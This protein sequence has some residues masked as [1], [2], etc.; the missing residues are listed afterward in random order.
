MLGLLDGKEV[1]IS[2]CCA[3]GCDDIEGCALETSLGIMLGLLDGK[4]VG[5]SECCALGCD[6]IEGCALGTS[7]G[8]DEGSDDIEG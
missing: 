7:L 1:G 4:E 2:V 3:L 5:I 8:I 6:D